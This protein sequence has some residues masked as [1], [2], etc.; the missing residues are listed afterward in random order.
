MGR[1]VVSSRSAPH[2]LETITF[3]TS[4]LAAVFR[5]SIHASATNASAFSLASSDNVSEAA[6]LFFTR[7]MRR[8]YLVKTAM[9]GAVIK[10]SQL[11]QFFVSTVP[12]KYFVSPSV[13]TSRSRSRAF[14]LRHVE[15]RNTTCHQLV[16]FPGPES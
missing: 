6:M 5:G 8:S 3:G 9:I 15:F 14:D 2:S 12:D 4:F 13:R 11:A 1:I 16:M 7:A 10:S